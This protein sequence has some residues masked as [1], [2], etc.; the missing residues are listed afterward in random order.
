MRPKLVL[1][2]FPF[3]LPKFTWLKTLKNS[4]LNLEDLVL[5][6]LRSLDQRDVEVDV[7]R[8]MEHVTA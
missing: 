4:D 5:T 2:M 3:G 8:S 6:D 1:P 7:A